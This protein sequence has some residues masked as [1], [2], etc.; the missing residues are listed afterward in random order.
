MS[1][2]YKTKDMMLIALFAS[3]TAIGAFVKIPTPIVPFSLQYLFCAYSGILLGAKKGLYSQL[4]YLGIGLMGFPV[5]TQGGGPTYILQPTFGYIIGFSLCSYIVGKLTER[6]KKITFTGLLTSILAGMSAVY[7]CG[8]V[9]LYLVMNFYLGTSM[10]IK[11]A[12]I[13][14]LF[15]FIFTDLIYSMLIALTAAAII[16][17]LKRLGL[18]SGNAN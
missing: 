5:F 8:I 9:H 16:P 10:T 17:S 12:I 7:M 15:P 1:L 18:V 4:L 2:N 3:L 6:L 11:A 13:T 14:G